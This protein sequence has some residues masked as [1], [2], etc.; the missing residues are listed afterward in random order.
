MTFLRQV[1]N[2]LEVE[3]SQRVI[4]LDKVTWYKSNRKVEVV[5]SRT[6]FPLT[7]FYASTCHRV[8]GLTLD[9]A[10]V[11]SCKEFVPGLIYVAA[12]RVRHEDQLQLVNFHR[13]QLIPPSAE[14][15]TVCRNDN[16]VVEDSCRCCNQKYIEQMLFAVCDKG[17]EYCDERDAPESLEVDASPDG[18]VLSFFEHE[19]DDV[20][21]DLALM[22][23][24]LE[25]HEEELSCLQADINIIQQVQE[26]MV[27]SPMSIFANIMNLPIQS[28]LDSPQIDSREINS[29]CKNL[30][31]Q[32]ISYI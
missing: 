12:S 28:I 6:Q 9:A 20:I 11:H 17:E 23:G 27:P 14:V 32:D 30:V 1:G 26:G 29:S 10:V 3:I 16:E 25:E 18:L 5:G 19:D 22:Y 24:T 31:V 15:L 13:R 21:V 4:R 2:Q 8:Q 7:L